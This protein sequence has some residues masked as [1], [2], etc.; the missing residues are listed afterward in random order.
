MSLGPVKENPH[1]YYRFLTL[2]ITSFSLIYCQTNR[3]VSISLS[4]LSVDGFL[5]RYKLMHVQPQ[6][7]LVL[8]SCELQNVG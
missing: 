6:P 7:S 3:T 2:V 1:P 8:S 5:G 4:N